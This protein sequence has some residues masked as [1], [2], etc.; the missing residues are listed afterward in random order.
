MGV[1]SGLGSRYV[2]TAKS[3]MVER[4]VVYIVLCGSTSVVRFPTD[5]SST[6]YVALERARIPITWRS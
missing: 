4:T 3:P 5:C 1:G 2:V 6:T